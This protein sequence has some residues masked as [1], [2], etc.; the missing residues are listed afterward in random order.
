NILAKL[1]NKY[2]LVVFNNSSYEE[3]WGLKLSRLNMFAIIGSSAIILIAIVISIIA[4]TPLREF[5]PGYPD[6]NMRSIIVSNVEKLDSLE[7]EILIRD[8]YFNNIKMIIRGETPESI[9]PSNNSKVK[10]K[11]V[12]FKKS[13]NDSI[14]REQIEKEELFN[15][16]MFSSQK[17][18]NVLSKIYFYPPV[19]GTVSAQFNT[20]IKHYGTDITPQDNVVMATLDGTVTLASWTAETGYVIQIQHDNNFISMYK[21]N[22]E[23]LKEVGEIVEA[24]EAIAIIG[25]SDELYTSGPHLHFEL[26]HNGKPLNPEDYIGF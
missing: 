26:W 8:S 5:I 23:L 4:F 7:Q 11:D 13:E 20:N 14:L 12:N 19:K 15:L 21:H 18:K 25:N 6:G 2:R 1:R 9:E 10:S 22:V 16:S 17:E 3:V 24:G